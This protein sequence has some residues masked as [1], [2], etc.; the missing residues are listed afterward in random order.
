M[1]ISPPNTLVDEITDFLVS[2]PTPEQIIEFQTSEALN[3]R[4]HDLLDK[5]REEGL[6]PEER[7]ELNH[8]LEIGHLFIMLKA[9]ARLKLIGKE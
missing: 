4:L 2:S 5:N 7:D 3:E 9:K 8:F 6:T 1:D